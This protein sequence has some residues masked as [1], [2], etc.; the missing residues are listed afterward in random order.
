MW[1]SDILLS[2]GSKQKPDSCI[3]SG[4]VQTS[5]PGPPSKFLAVGPL[6][7]CVKD[8]QVPSSPPRIILLHYEYFNAI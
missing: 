6:P 1:E 8:L 4:D 2:I 5:P 3:H 7:V